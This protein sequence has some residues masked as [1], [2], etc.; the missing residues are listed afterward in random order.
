MSHASSVPEVLLQDGLGYR[1]APGGHYRGCMSGPVDPG[2]LR[3]GATERD[4]AIAAIGEHLGAGRLDLYEY[5]RRVGAA[6]QARTYADLRPLFADL[7]PPHPLSSLA[8]AGAGPGHLPA[9]LTDQ[10]TAEGLLVLAADIAGSMT[11]RRYRAP[12]Q[13]IYRRKI[14]IRGT[15]AVSPRRLLI[16]AAGATRVDMPFVHPLWHAIEVSADRSDLLRVTVH[17][18]AFDHHR[19]G[20]IVLR[21][22]TGEA[23]AVAALLATTR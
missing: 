23:T 10:L 5:E 7:P 14:G 12:G 9:D 4:A 20:R 22:R 19:S 18:G 8:V 6:A 3:I 11:Y 21:L 13:R 15:V 2:G 17:V 16:W 1:L